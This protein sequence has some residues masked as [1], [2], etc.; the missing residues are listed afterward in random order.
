MVRNA[1]ADLFE[2]KFEAGDPPSADM[3]DLVNSVIDSSHHAALKLV[4][5]RRFQESYKV[6]LNGRIHLRG[7]AGP[8]SHSCCSHG[9]C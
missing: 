1:M 4:R 6:D 8:E 5:S 3:G 9:S 2:E 7:F